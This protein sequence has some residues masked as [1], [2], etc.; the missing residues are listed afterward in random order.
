VGT[1]GH[2]AHGEPPFV[3]GGDLL[4]DKSER[5]QCERRFK[6]ETVGG[7]VEK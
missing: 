7:A 1:I 4:L 5:L 3:A 6:T 2:D